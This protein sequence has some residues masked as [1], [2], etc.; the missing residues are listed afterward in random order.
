MIK[1]KRFIHEKF[2][3]TGKKRKRMKLINRI[4]INRNKQIERRKNIMK[5][6]TLKTTTTKRPDT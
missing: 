4:E 2:N 5:Q 1:E 3:L 6:N